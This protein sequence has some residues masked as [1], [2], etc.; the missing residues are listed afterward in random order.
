MA[1][2]ELRKVPELNR[3]HCPISIGSGVR[4]TPEYARVKQQNR[5]HQVALLSGNLSLLETGPLASNVWIFKPG[6]VHIRVDSPF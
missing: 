1:R 2:T 3:N 4:Q 5:R 6:K